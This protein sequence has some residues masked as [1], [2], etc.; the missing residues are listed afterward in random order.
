MKINWQKFTPHLLAIGIFLLVAA[1]YCS[2]SLQGK[3]LQQSDMIHWRGMAAN[4]FKYKETHGHFPLW[5]NGMFGGMPTYQIAMDNTNPI[6]LGYLNSLFFLFLPAPICYFF[7]MCISFYF[8]CQV[9]KVN[10]WLGIFGGLAYAY[11]SFTPIIVTVGHVTQVLALGYF[12]ALLGSFFLV[13]QKKY[14][15]GGALS[16]IMSVMFIGQNHLQITYYFL[17][18]AFIATVAYTIHW[19]KQKDY[20]HIFITY[21][22]LLFAG[23]IGVGNNLVTLATTSDYAKATTRGGTLTLDSSGTAKTTTGLD[24]DYAFGWSYGIPETYSLLIPDVVGGQPGELKATSHLGKFITDQ[25]GDPDNASQFA[26]QFGTYWG[27][28]PFTSG[29]VYLGAVICFL[30]L[31]GL[32]YLKGTD[33]WWI[34]VTCALAILMSWG[35]NFE[36]FNSFLFQY[37]PLY[38]KFRVPTMTLI[39]PQVLFPL[40]AVLALQKFLF[41]DTNKAVAFKQLKTAGFIA[42]GLFAV[43]AMLYSSFDYKGVNDGQLQSY[44]SQM[45]RGDQG[46]ADKLYAALKADRQSLYGGDIL[47]SLF[48]VAAAFAVLFLLVKQKIKPLYAAL[49]L[50]L[51]GSADVISEG[52][53][54]LNNDSF[55]DQETIDENTTAPT[56][57]DVDIMKDTG[58]YRVLNLTTDVFNDAITSY[59][60][61]SVGGYHPAKLALTED[62]LDFQL[63]KQQMNINVLNMLNTKYVIVPGQNNQPVAQQN[64]A[65]LGACWFVKAIEFKKGPAEVMKALDNFNPADTAI[66]EES[67][68]SI[69]PFTPVADSAATISLVKN[70]ND[71][72]TYKTSS[73]TNQ[74]A[75]FSEIYYDRGWKAYIDNKEAPIVKTNYALR[76]L[77]VPAGTH[78][79]RFEFKPASYYQSTNIAIASSAIGWVAI[80]ATVFQMIRKRKKKITA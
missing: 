67:A 4:S 43:A 41:E 35:K 34:V 71:I 22:I 20:K 25:G 6:S 73:T 75:V 16:M 1:L 63:R 65:N 51:L 66:V 10:Y 48:F 59:H 13:F 58:Y 28:Q 17:I 61:L 7:L 9:L 23:A 52:R 46:T 57:A 21:A 36:S 24:I 39:I 76:G 50:L 64:P 72:V 68:K 8:L 53:R 3:V 32:V 70:D 77:A 31:F 80:A 12:P 44:F 14:W 60:H 5:T 30:F 55:Q 62:L 15:L 79:I 27:A 47:R 26:N 33:K 49:A 37:L 56:Q 40:L 19:I 29:P 69:I 11:A 18:V 2:P 45:A 74:F 42:I 78:D 38:N 54:Y